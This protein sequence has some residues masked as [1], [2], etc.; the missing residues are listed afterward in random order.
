MKQAFN[1]TTHQNWS[2]YRAELATYI[3]P[4]LKKD[5]LIIG[6]GFCSDLDLSLFSESNVT[7]LDADIDPIN[8][9]CKQQDFSDYKTIKADILGLDQTPFMQKLKRGLEKKKLR[10]TLKAFREVYEFDLDQTYDLIIV[11]PVYS[12]MLLPQIFKSI[13]NSEDMIQEA[14]TFVAE[15]IQLFHNILQGA[16]NEDGKLLSFSD[17][18]EYPASSKEA[19][20][21]IEADSQQTLKNHYDT[22][23]NSFGHGIASYALH[24]LSEEMNEING[25]FFIWPF[26]EQTVFMVKGGCYTNKND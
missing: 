4:H 18:I 23:I 2:T 25:N 9:G 13:R 12:L 19:Q 26:T 24:D 15:R 21:I 20:E 10:P 3:K 11:M 14:M 7:F 16:L 6:A 8:E 5:I 1:E 22:Y 17:V